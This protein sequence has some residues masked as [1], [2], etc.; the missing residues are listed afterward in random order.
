MLTS[1]NETTRAVIASGATV[2]NA[3]AAAGQSVLLL[4][5]D[6]THVLSQVGA[7]ALNTLVAFGA[8]ADAGSIVKTT[9]AI[10]AGNISANGDI[11]IL[12]DSREDVVSL[13]RTDQ[14]ALGLTIAGAGSYYTI[15]PVTRAEVGSGGNVTA[16]ENVVVSSNDVTAVDLNP[17]SSNAALLATVGASL[18]V[19]LL[20]KTTEAFVADN[21]I[22]SGHGNGAAVAVPDG[23]F[24]ISYVD[25]A[26]TL[27]EVKAPGLDLAHDILAPLFSFDLIKIVNVDPIVSD[28][29]L[30]QQRV[31]TPHTHMISGLS[32]T[33]LST[34]D[35][36]AQASGFGAALATSPQFSIVAD[37]ASNRTAAYIG[38]GA[39]VN[40]DQTGSNANQQVVVAAGSD[41]Y[42]MAIAGVSSV[43]LAATVGPS[44]TDTSVNNATIAEIDANAVVNSRTDVTVRAD[45]AE[46]ILS[47]TSA[48][49]GGIGLGIGGSL[50]VISTNG[51]TLSTIGDAA[52]VSATGNILVV[53][54]DVTSTDIDA[55]GDGLGLGPES[56]HRPGLPCSRRVRPP[57]SGR[58]LCWTPRARPR[59][60][61]M[62]P[63]GPPAAPHSRRRRF[64]EWGSRRS[65]KKAGSPSPP[66]GP[67]A[68]GSLP[69]GRFQLP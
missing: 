37:V 3:G 55:G 64:T 51:T 35:V 63:M 29:S 1:L 69:P 60:R 58:A 40:A 10:A 38:A 67:R 22:V 41:S 7:A 33:A 2:S 43:A 45:A 34:D 48:F 31:A 19:A 23:T 59:A 4:A 13:A 15:A 50:A 61:S 27:G 68:M 47:F 52:Q 36:E 49:S 25:D 30:K 39:K 46:D 44:A 12:A 8:G 11:T 6:K 14:L 57:R 5:S 65:R 32:V 42:H 26:N 24:D 54:R 62:S 9:E 66:P 56:A 28:P 21:A 20:N 18:G 17:D 16:N 53:A